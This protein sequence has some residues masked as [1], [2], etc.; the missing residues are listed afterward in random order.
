MNCEIP[1]DIAQTS[2]LYSQLT[3]V[4]AGFSFTA[5]VIAI[6]RTLEGARQTAPDAPD[7]VKGS[8]DEA[9]PVMVCS[10]L[11]LVISSLTYSAIAGDAKNTGRASIEELVGGLA[12]SI[13]GILMFYSIVLMLYMA[14]SDDAAKH[15]RMI[16]GQ[17]ITLV[18]FAY[19]CNGIN[20]YNEVH[21]RLDG[22]PVPDWETGII[23]G[24]LG[25]FSIY[26]I[27]GYLIYDKLWRLSGTDHQR[28]IKRLATASLLTVIACAVGVGVFSA[29]GSK[30][31]DTPPPW[32]PIS[33]MGV[34]FLVSVGFSVWLFLSRKEERR[35]WRGGSSS[36][37][38]DPSS[39][40]LSA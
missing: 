16:L 10:F 39:S 36:G 38:S 3:G 34:S 15:G 14:K 18:S 37:P 22:K 23:Y 25:L 6:S 5:I 30:P 21:F 11:G 1:F 29:Y 4:L 8:L 28:A 24:L 27:A 19:I 13:S 17:F 40:P 12:F 33:L 35:P 32:V 20:D 26:S 7:E 9:L 2:Q 31:C